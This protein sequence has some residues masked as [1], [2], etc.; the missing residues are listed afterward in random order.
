MTI[1]QL[2]NPRRFPTKRFYITPLGVKLMDDRSS[3]TI[4]DN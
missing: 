2:A 1:A 3:I 4:G